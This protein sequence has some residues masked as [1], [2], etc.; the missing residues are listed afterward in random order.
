MRE[1]SVST[2]SYK[3]TVTF[4]DVFMFAFNPCYVE[5]DITTANGSTVTATTFSVTVASSSKSVSIDVAILNGHAKAYISRLLQYLFTDVLEERS[6]DVT[7]TATATTTSSVTTSD[8][9]E[10]LA[11]VA[12]EALWSALQ[13]GEQFGKY[14]VYVANKYNNGIDHIRDVVWFPNF[15]F[16]VSLFRSQSDEGLTVDIDGTRTLQ[17]KTLTEVGIF[18]VVPSE[19]CD[20]VESVKQKVVLSIGLLGTDSQSTFT[21]VFDYT[22]TG[23]LD[24][25]REKVNLQI[26]K[27]TAGYYFR[28]I[29]QFGFLQYYLFVKGERTSKN[30]LSSN[31]LGYEQQYNGMYFGNIIRYQQVT[32]QDTVKCSAV[33]LSE[34]V[35]AYVE[36]IIKSPY[37]DLY[38]GKDKRGTE[39]WLPVNVV[40]GSYKVSANRIL[41]DYEI[42]FTLPETATQS[43]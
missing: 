11:T 16:K 2:S 43:L 15:P 12:G 1:I 13:I 22:F 29:D 37:V 42:S 7:I 21:T 18:E 9:K 20:D 33:N 41:R 39:I 38:L 36:T 35:L 25:L 4:P 14:G 8:G 10:E 23:T 30:K 32:N 28:W 26:D 27:S 24:V 40:A 3:G 19:L 17:N 5:F 6:I 34:R 31:E